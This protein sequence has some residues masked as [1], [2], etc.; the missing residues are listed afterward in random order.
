MITTI[1]IDI[2]NTLLDFD[3][4]AYLSMKSA[5]EDVGLPFEDYMFDTFERI[6]LS[7]W[8][9]LEEKIISKD[10]LFKIRWSTILAALGFDYDGIDMEKRFKHYICTY[11]VTIDGAED[12]LKHLSSKYKVY[13]TSNATYDQQISRLKNAGLDK[14]FDGYF[15]SERAGAEKPSKEFFDYCFG[16]LTEQIDNIVLIG[17]SPTADIKGGCQ[18]GLSTIW[19]NWRG[20]KL[21]EGVNPTYIVKSLAEIKKIL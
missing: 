10:Q 14:Y 19:F 5:F 15:I 8:H 4:C 12:I 18:Y 7:L 16:N 6:N 2:D 9:R 21:P 20:E 17:D 13:A 11:A 1:F 3:K